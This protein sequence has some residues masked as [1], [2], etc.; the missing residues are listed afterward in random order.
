MRTAAG[1]SSHPAGNL[2]PGKALS[3]DFR[4]PFPQGPGRGLSCRPT[5]VLRRTGAAGQS[6]ALAS[7]LAPLR[8]SEW[9]VYAE[10]PIGPFRQH[11]LPTGPPAHSLLR[12]PSELPPSRSGAVVRPAGW[13]VAGVASTSSGGDSPV[14]WRWHAGSTLRRRARSP[15]LAAGMAPG[16]DTSGGARVTIH[17]PLFCSSRAGCRT[18]VRGALVW[19]RVCGQYRTAY[20][21]PRSSSRLLL[22]CH[23]AARNRANLSV[24]E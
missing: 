23:P 13:T 11:S 16:Q 9:V 6:G 7:C 1:G 20:S 17:G 19:P 24:V 2:L 4:R 22:P 15:A 12:L 14:C 21:I 10:P 18:G 5:P 8:G 3:R